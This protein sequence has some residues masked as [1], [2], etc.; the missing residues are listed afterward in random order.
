MDFL[1]PGTNTDLT[2]T[3]KTRR[4]GRSVGVVDIDVHDDQGKL[5][6]IGRG[7]YSPNVG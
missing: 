4:L 1:R 3:A 2:A 5:C 7:T 6:A